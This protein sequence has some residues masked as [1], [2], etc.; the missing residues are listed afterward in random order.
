ML[1]GKT[2]VPGGRYS[3]SSSADPTFADLWAS[4]FQ[5]LSPDDK[6]VQKSATIRLLFT[7]PSLSNTSHIPVTPK[8]NPPSDE[9]GS[10]FGEV[11]RRRGEK[12]IR[13]AGKKA[14][15]QESESSAAGVQVA[16]LEV[17]APGAVKMSLSENP[18]GFHSSRAAPSARAARR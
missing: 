3:S 18:S 9:K 4:R 12:L 15:G 2:Y 11:I 8:C 1:K 10:P 7:L 16:M 17:D 6:S 13:A 5:I 14:G